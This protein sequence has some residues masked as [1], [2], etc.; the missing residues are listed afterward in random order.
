MS[1]VYSTALSK[2]IKRHLWGQFQ[3][4]KGD[5]DDDDDDDDDGDDDDEDEDDEEEDDDDDE[6]EDDEEEEDD[7]DDDDRRGFA[8]HILHCWQ[9]EG[10]RGS[11]TSTA[12]R[13]SFLVSV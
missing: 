2:K 11:I 8:E 6:D 9:R 1:I 4:R 13:P 7:D 10:A 12:W 5:D 3:K